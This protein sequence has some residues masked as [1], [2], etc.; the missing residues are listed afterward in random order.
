MQKVYNAFNNASPIRYR[1][2]TADS[3]AA[4]THVAPEVLVSKVLARMFGRPQAS[5]TDLAATHTIAIPFTG[6]LG[7]P[8]GPKYHPRLTDEYKL[9]FQAGAAGVPAVLVGQH[10]LGIFK[11]CS[12]I[13][14]KFDM[15]E[16]LATAVSKI[17]TRPLLSSLAN[18]F[19]DEALKAY[20]RLQYR[21]DSQS[22]NSA[23]DFTERDGKKGDTKGE[24]GYDPAVAVKRGK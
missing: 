4:A 18:F 6:G 13:H 1:S 15:K 14:G 12:L 19:P 24:I 17:I 20:N 5:W 16:F 10:I 9:Q 2:L 21:F 7:V 23:L 8:I 11:G 22:E 3:Y